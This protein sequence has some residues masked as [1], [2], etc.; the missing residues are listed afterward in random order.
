MKETRANRVCEKKNSRNLT[1]RELSIK[2]ET[3]VNNTNRM[4]HN[5]KIKLMSTLSLIFIYIESALDPF[6]ETSSQWHLAGDIN[7]SR[8]YIYLL[9]NF[10][11]SSVTS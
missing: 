5:C 10:A 1:V 3:R 6:K 11:I 9:I 8:K 4:F 2:Q 7:A